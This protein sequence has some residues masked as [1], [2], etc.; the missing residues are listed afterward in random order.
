MF[1]Y[2]SSAFDMLFFEWICIPHWI[3]ADKFADLTKEKRIEMATKAC[4]EDSRLTIRKAAKIYQ[5]AHTTISRRIE[6]LTKPRKAAHASQQLLTPVEEQII[7]KWAIQ[8]YKW[9]LPL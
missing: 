7:I 8:Y 9:G 5:I 1:I 3:M 4:A 2:Y 6:G